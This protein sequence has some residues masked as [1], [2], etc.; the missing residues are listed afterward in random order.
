MPRYLALY[1]LFVAALL[2]MVAIPG[3]NLRIHHY[4]LALLLLP[5]TAFQNRPSL[6]YQGLLVG[7]FVN[8]IARWGFDSILQ[9]PTELLKGVQQGS[10]LPAVAVAARAPGNITFDLG[11]LPRWDRRL[12]TRYDGLSILVND[13]EQFRGYADG[14]QYWDD[15]RL[16]GDNFTWTWE[17]HVVHTPKDAP[18]RD[19]SAGEAGIK[20]LPE[21]F[22]FGYMAG[23]ATADFGKAGKWEADG[24]W[25]EMEGGPS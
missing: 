15:R 24:T 6:L 4:I 14:R 22:R 11:A 12:A 17:R 10:L 2:L 20:I 1:A 25:R 8:G 7:L 16:D 18:G 21:Y 3:L 19:G 13:V 9:T 23:S 5:G